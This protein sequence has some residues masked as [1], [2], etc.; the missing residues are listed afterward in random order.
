MAERRSVIRNLFALLLLIAISWPATGDDA[1]PLTAILLI[2][3][4]ELPDPN[5]NGAT[6]LVM[7]DIA[8]G[9]FGIIV[10]RPTKVTVSQ[11]FPDIR[12]GG[13]GDDNVYFGG[14]VE[15][16]TVSF[17][18]RAD[19]PPEHGVE[20][21]DGLYL[22]RDLELLHDLLQKPPAKATLR[23]FIGY[24]GWA[25]DQLENEIARG[26]WTLA[27]ATAAT[28]FDANPEHPWPEPPVPERHRI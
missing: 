18:F 1:K 9:P 20:V 4:G 26:D 8:N 24:A 5:F 21:V 10:N 11:L 2:A 22:S 25:A 15:L 12:G 27:P 23:I 7:N 13:H 17:L 28:I 19:A 14:P 3:R 16:E 6:V